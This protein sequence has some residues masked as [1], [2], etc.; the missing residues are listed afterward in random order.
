VRST[1]LLFTLS[2]TSV[3]VLGEKLDQSHLS[4]NI[5]AGHDAAPRRRASQSVGHAA[6]A[7]PRAARRLGV[8]V[9]WARLLEAPAC[10]PQA[11]RAPKRLKSPP[12]PCHASAAGRT[13]YCPPVYR[14]SL[15]APTPRGTAV[16]AGTSRRSDRPPIK[17]EPARL[18][19]CV[20]PSTSPCSASGHC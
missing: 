17:I 6:R 14:E 20:R 18:L 11:A 5:R 7:V 8:R 3:Q 16:R 19:A 1:T 4:Q 2:C 9:L 12:S 13:G 10:L 15:L